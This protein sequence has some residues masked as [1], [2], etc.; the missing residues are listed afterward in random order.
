M[1]YALTPEDSSMRFLMPSLQGSAPRTAFLSFVSLRKSI[2]ISLATSIIC[3]KYEGVHA[4]TVTSRSC[5][6]SSCLSVLPV[7]AGSTD[8]PT[9]SAP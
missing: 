2:P 3:M 1:S 5:I 4:M 7:L 8:A 9:R 6:S